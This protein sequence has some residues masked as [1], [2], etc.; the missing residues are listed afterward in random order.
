M[1][2]NNLITIKYNKSLRL[3]YKERTTNEKIRDCTVQY[4][5]VS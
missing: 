2:F 3:L 5:T 1:A 4:D